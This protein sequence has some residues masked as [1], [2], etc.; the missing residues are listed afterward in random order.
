LY[1]VTVDGGKTK[2]VCAVLDAEGNV[3]SYATG[4]AIGSSLLDQQTIEFNL[5]SVVFDALARSSL[6]AEDIGV[7][8]FSVCDLDTKELMSNMERIILKL[9]F[10]GKV[11]LEPDFV[12]AYYVATHG[13]P[14]VGVIAGTGSMAYGEN[15]SGGRAR[16]GGWGWLINDEGSGFW[17]GAKALNAVARAYDGLS[18]ETSLSEAIC[19][20]LNLSDCLDLMNFTYKDRS[21]DPLLASR[22]APLVDLAAQEGDSQAIRILEQAAHELSLMALTVSRR[23]ELTKEKHV[24]GCI[25]SVFKSNIVLERFKET[26]KREE[27]EV[28]IRGPYID[29]APLMGP[30]VIALK[31]LG[32]ESSEMLLETI[33]KNL[34]KIS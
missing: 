20:E 33:N 30:T 19:K 28:E 13:K 2:T 32:T 22:I 7:A 16:A 11:F 26:M 4:R 12:S 31:E 5:R 21:A 14:G 23:L 10:K 29:Y 9:G 17:I 18:K 27:K 3:L 6:G 8:S 25:G 34:E 1:I 24:V 15:G